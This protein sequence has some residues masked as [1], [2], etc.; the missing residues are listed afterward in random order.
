MHHTNAGFKDFDLFQQAAI[1]WDLDFRLLSKNDFAGNLALFSNQVIQIS[2]A[3]LHGKIEQRGLCPQGFR[4]I[5]IPI[6][7]TSQFFWLNKETEEGQI[8]IFPKDGILDAIS[9]NHFDVFVISIEETY[10][11]ELIECFK[12][13][14]CLV[15]FRGTEVR[16]RPS[17]RF[18]LRLQE[19]IK[20]LSRNLNEI[21]NFKGKTEE[22]FDEIIHLLLQEINGSTHQ[23]INEKSF[24][25]E[26]GLK[27]AVEIIN[28]HIDE[29]L[30]IYTLCKSVGLS[31]RSLQ[32]AFKEKY[33]VTPK[34]YMRAIKL[35][36]IKGE[37]INNKKQLISTIA[38]KYGIWHM[39][40][41]AA[42]FKKQFG[43]LP[44]Q[45]HS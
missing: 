25:R 27:K 33:P 43:V 18:N 19:L 6:N 15:H 38:A 34:D 23:D 36:A 21:Q 29:N 13:N 4:S 42:D 37:L 11:M 2:R 44:S 45:L 8:L 5:A 32:N 17:H 35:N 16:L 26:K 40:Q 10:L 7:S 28:H 24:R 9:F 20:T 1:E 39:G 30:S 22:C 41:F 12:F 14:N 31:E 3:S